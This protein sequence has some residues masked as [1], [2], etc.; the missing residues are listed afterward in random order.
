MEKPAKITK[1]AECFR[2]IGFQNDCALKRKEWNW[3]SAFESAA[4]LCI[5]VFLHQ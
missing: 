5:A 2:K 4:V 1:I 3:H